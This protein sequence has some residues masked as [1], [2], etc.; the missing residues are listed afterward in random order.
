M[1]YICKICNAS[2]VG[3][4]KRKLKTRLN[5]HVK[6][7]RL[8]PQK[9]CYFGSY[10]RNHESKYH[11]RLILKMIRQRTT[12]WTWNKSTKLLDESYFNILNRLVKDTFW[13]FF[14]IFFIIFIF[15]FNLLLSWPL[16]RSLTFQIL[17][18]TIKVSIYI[19]A[20]L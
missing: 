20:L 2:Y 18:Y 12:K 10:F 6:N 11:K 4:T 1:S 3:Q 16:Q 15:M 13:L 17:Y 8:D 9:H 14:I 7:I 5:E 19:F